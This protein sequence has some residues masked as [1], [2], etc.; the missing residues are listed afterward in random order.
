MRILKFTCGLFKFLLAFKQDAL[1]TGR[2]VNV[3]AI[4]LLTPTVIAQRPF[5]LE[6]GDLRGNI[7]HRN[8]IF[9]CFCKTFFMNVFLPSRLRRKIFCKATNRDVLFSD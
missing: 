7:V 8:E 4:E 9:V 2:S 6:R 1:L 3:I 5:T